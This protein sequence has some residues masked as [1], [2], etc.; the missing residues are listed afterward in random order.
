MEDTTAMPPIDGDVANQEHKDVPNPINPTE[1]NRRP[2]PSDE[3]VHRDIQAGYRILNLLDHGFNNGF[4]KVEQG[5]ETFSRFLAKRNEAIYLEEKK[6][7]LENSLR[8]A[9]QR[10][11]QRRVFISSRLEGK[12]VHG[13][14]REFTQGEMA[15]LDVE[16]NRNVG[17]AEALSKKR[18]DIN[19]EYGWVAALMFFLAGVVFI[20]SDMAITYNITANAYMMKGFES[21]IF[22]IGLGLTAFLMK[23]LIDRYFEREYQENGRQMIKKV[24]LFYII[25]GL[26]AVLILIILGVFRGNVQPILDEIGK[27]D[28]QVTN[29]D[30]L[31]PAELQRLNERRLELYSLIANNPYGVWGFV[32]SGLLFAL[33][34]AVSL[35]IAFPS[36]TGLMNRYWKLPYRIWILRRRI[37][38]D[39]KKLSGLRQRNITAA[40]MLTEIV[41]LASDPEI[42]RLESEIAAL[43]AELDL[44]SDGLQKTMGE[45]EISLY[46]DGYLRGEKYPFILK[47]TVEGRESRESVRPYKRRP[48]IEVRKVIANRAESMNGRHTVESQEN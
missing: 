12:T 30:E 45:L 46:M 6:K 20:I 22:A 32:L 28:T 27:L 42:Q 2:D 37:G 5:A 25:L 33:G 4:H 24:T 10:L 31:L 48:F 13:I 43:K 44:L 11:S 19:P 41:E 26:I 36:L 14:E 47:R 21:W 34:G 7:G 18:E 15:R 9:V 35:S 39:E 29:A 23:P 1:S 38:K 16:I 8:E 3:L 40:H 17:R